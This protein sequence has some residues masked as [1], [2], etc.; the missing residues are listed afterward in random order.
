M[1]KGRKRV[2][3]GVVGITAAVIGVA[4]AGHVGTDSNGG[5]KPYGL[6][7]TLPGMVS[8]FGSN[9][10]VVKII[11]GSSGVYYQVIG[12]D[13]QLHIRDYTI[14]QSE[15]DAGTYGYNRKTTNVVRAPTVVESRS[16]VVTLGQIDP[17]V[18]DSLYSKVGFPRQGS[19]ATLTGRS[20]FLESGAQPEHRFVAAYDGH[21]VQRTQSAAPPDPNI[22]PTPT[23]PSTVAN[24]SNTTTTYSLTTTITSGAPKPGKLSRATQRLT[25]CITRARGDVNKIVVCQRKFVP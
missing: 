17:S 16:A 23:T 7:E 22:A 1:S 6:G 13:R 18:V 21:A 11:V 8:S 3:V 20:W 25:T 14:A 19:S 24:Q 15:I 12:S 10:R 2:V 9:A 5:L 4:I